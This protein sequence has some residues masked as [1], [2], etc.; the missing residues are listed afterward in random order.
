MKAMNGVEEEE[1]PDALVE[2]VAATAEVV[3]LSAVFKER[4]DGGALAQ[5]IQREIAPV[6]SAGNDACQV[7]HKDEPPPFAASS[8]SARS[9]SI[10]DSTSIRFRPLRARASWAINRSEEHTSELQS[11]R[12]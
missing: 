2:V 7:I 3:E 12:H 10:C 1:C 8:R 6:F 5:G 9:S 4:L 11:L